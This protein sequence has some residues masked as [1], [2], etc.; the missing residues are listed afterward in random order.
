VEK[1]EVLRILRLQRQRLREQYGVKS[2]ALF[3]SVARDEARTASDIDVLVEFERPITLFQLVAVREDLQ[4]AL[5]APN[6]DVVPR[7]CIFP[8]LKESI[9]A[10]AIDVD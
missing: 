3:G 9:L 1:N 4:R 2:M 8:E 6:V 7:D 10:G 5:G